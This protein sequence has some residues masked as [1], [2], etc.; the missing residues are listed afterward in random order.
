M[1]E[2]SIFIDES[3]DVG[4]CSEYYLVTFIL[5]D[6]STDISEGI[7]KYQEA[8]S[9][10]GL[11]EKTFHFAPVLRG[12]EQFENLGIEARKGYLIRFHIL[13]EK[14]PFRYFTLSYR[15]SQVANVYA[16]AESIEKDLVR[17]LREHLAYFQQFDK[18]K[19][20][21]DNGQRVVTYAVHQAVRTCLARSAAVYRK[22][23]SRDYHLSQV[24]DYVCGIEL[25]ALRHEK[26]TD[27]PTDHR[28]FGDR[29]SFSRN[30]LRKVRK[31]LL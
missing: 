26:H 25:A 4:D 28:F 3:G 18:V 31:K 11:Q 24:A 13:V 7:R 12:H 16:L 14:M 1:R 17:F 5:H 15:K 21:Y 6:Q 27:N 8:L 22:A 19:V 20:Y 30:Y 10:A 2:L 23:L 9:N 29:R